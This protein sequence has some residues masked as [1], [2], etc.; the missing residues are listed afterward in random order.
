[1]DNDYKCHICS[2]TFKFPKQ[3]TQHYQF[4]TNIPNL[5]FPCCFPDCNASWKTY[6]GF[7]SHF[8]RNHRNISSAP[9]FENH[10]INFNCTACT[11]SFSSYK[12][13]I[14]HI[15]THLRSHIAIIC[16][17]D[18]C[19]RSF[20]KVPSFSSH[21]SRYHKSKITSNEVITVNDCSEHSLQDSTANLFDTGDENSNDNVFVDQSLVQTNTALA[22][23]DLSLFYMKLQTQYN[24]PSN[25]LQ[26]IFEELN[27]FSLVN[28]TSTLNFISTKLVNEFGLSPTVSQTLMTEAWQNNDF[29]KTQEL[30]KTD[31]RR[32]IYFKKEFGYI[33]PVSIRL[34]Y[35]GVNKLV[36]F[37]YIP[38]LKS[39][40]AFLK[41][42]SVLS[43]LNES[44]AITSGVLID[45]KNAYCF[46]NHP[47]WKS[48]KLALQIILYT[49][50]F[51][52][53]NP[54]G[55]AKNQHKILSV[56]YS[57][58][59]LYPYNQSKV[60]ALQLV[61]LCKEEDY[62]TFGQSKV[63]DPLI[64][65]LKILES[66]GI[67]VPNFGIIKGSILFVAGDNLGSHNIGGYTENFSSTSHVCRYCTATQQ[68]FEKNPA[69]I[70]SKMRTIKNYNDCLKEKESLNLDMFVGIKFDSML[71]SLSYYHVC[72]PGMP[73]CIGHD[74]FEGIIP[75][76]LCLIFKHFI[77]VKKIFTYNLLNRKI[78]KFPFKNDDAANKPGYFSP[79]N[80]IV[81]HAVQNWCLIRFITLIIEESVIDRND[82]VWK[83][84]CLLQEI[85]ALICTRT[86]NEG[87]VAYLKLLIAEYLDDRK[88]LFPDVPLRPKHHYMAHYPALFLKYGPLIWLWTMRFESKHAYFKKAI[89]QAGNFVNVTLTMSEKHQL[90]QAYLQTGQYFS[91]G[92]EMKQATH[93]IASKY[94]ENIL[95]AIKKC[96]FHNVNVPIVCHSAN[97]HGTEFKTGLV[98][99]ITYDFPIIKFGIIKLILLKQST[100]HFVIQPVHAEKIIDQYAFELQENLL[101]FE[102]VECTLLTSPPMTI[103]DINHKRIV[104]PK[105]AFLT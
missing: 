35:N 40:T 85:T 97:V 90:H 32:K 67:N 82:P 72:E 15:K 61:L 21:L 19:L 91:T 14:A 50:S 5:T 78:K 84:L 39:L 79:K 86:V 24:I 13:L 56:Y 89:R 36:F 44:L 101:P 43:Q 18:S 41:N 11:D 96:S 9:Q 46:L 55:S 34:G 88:N 26:S 98:I 75:Y 92:V 69:I 47:F 64:Q 83:L 33:E 66:E 53:A 68:E 38:I 51:E 94:E 74:L 25:A 12:S 49:D 20:T 102:C 60:N 28:L 77:K 52:I 62:K 2:E 99:L 37:H 45:H 54:L 103:Y 80:K 6:R 73:P 3:Y 42:D 58:G 81:G 29:L 30:L 31:Y 17:F 16:P 93:F 59:N 7:K 100:V 27:K 57:L 70:E 105:H 63:L 4:H 10:N 87:Q 1:M 104:V 95:S 22:V 48:Q 65:D 8:L 71:N 76:D 23:K